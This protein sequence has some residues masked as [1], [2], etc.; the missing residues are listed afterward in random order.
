VVGPKGQPQALNVSVGDTD[1]SLTEVSGPG[2]QSGLKV[3]TGQLTAIV[4][5]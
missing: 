1:G 4:A 2:V 5:R 3:I